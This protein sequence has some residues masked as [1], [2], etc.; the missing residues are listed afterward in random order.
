[1]TTVKLPTLVDAH[2]HFRE[3]GG[4]HKEDFASGSQ[5]A[6]AGG[7]AV[8]LEMPNT[9]PPTVDQP[10][11]AEKARI[12]TS[13]A[14]CDFGLFV[15]ATA[16]NA[17]AVAGLGPQAAGLKIYAGPTYGPLMLSD[18][19]ALMAHFAAWRGPGPI[20]VH[21]EGPMIAVSIAL[22][23]A[24]GRPT[25]ICHV[26]RAYEV[27]LIRRAKAAGVPVTC[28]VTPHHL[29]LTDA[30]AARLGP[31]GQMKP[32]LG[33][34][35]DR[36]ALWANLDVID[37]IATDHA[38][39]TRQEKEGDNPPPGVP[40]VETMLPLLLTAVAEGRLSLQDLVARLHTN[41]A[42][43]YGLKLPDAETVVDLDAPGEL[44]DAGLFTRC[45]WTPFAGMPT[46]GRV[47][48][49]TL[50]GRLAFADGRVLV[51]AGFGRNVRLQDKT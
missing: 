15:G 13:K 43:I 30:D 45:G 5:A 29:F 28:E 7:V 19:P 11:L 36:A 26:S 3:P 41:P 34:A 32:A 16:D 14:H 50:R 12:A 10:A 18:L 37:I 25:H 27:E 49:V 4:T 40:G 35:S 33:S 6:L 2:V 48:S 31:Y 22:A 8:V 17:E 51:P 20:A 42:R 24:Y 39:H 1:V 23:R 9:R 46:R 47:L 44:S 21:A 38:P